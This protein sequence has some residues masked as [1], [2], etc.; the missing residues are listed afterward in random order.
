[1]ETGLFPGCCRYSVISGVQ[2]R[3][4]IALAFLDMNI[5]TATSQERLLR[6]AAARRGRP[7]DHSTPAGG[8]P[9]TPNLHAR[10]PF[11]GGSFKRIRS[12]VG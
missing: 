2:A 4:G 5:D 7:T 1:M 8:V 12:D 11:R 6:S 10:K 9:T 3:D